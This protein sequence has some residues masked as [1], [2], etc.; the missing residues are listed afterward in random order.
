MVVTIRRVWSHY[1][2][3]TDPK[4]FKYSNVI[5][6]DERGVEHLLITFDAWMASL[7]LQYE[8]RSSTL[9]TQPPAVDLVWND[10]GK[11]LDLKVEAA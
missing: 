4:R 10:R 6:K 5:A 3:T 9:E 8:K 11:I 2:Y 1:D 7:C